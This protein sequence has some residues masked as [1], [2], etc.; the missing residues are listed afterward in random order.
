VKVGVS[1][2]TLTRA[3]LGELVAAAV[4]AERA[5]CATVWVPESWCRDPFGVLHAMGNATRRVHLA[6]GVAILAS[7]TPTAM[8]MA[9]QTL[10]EAHPGRVVL[11][12]GAGHAET[13]EAWHGVAHDSSLAALEEYIAIIRQV[14]SGQPL[15]PAG[16]RWDVRDIASATPQVTSPPPIVVA[17]L[18]PRAQALAAR[19]ADGVV[20]TM[21]STDAV[22]ASAASLQGKSLAA[23][24]MAGLDD[25]DR[26]A[27]GASVALYG[28]W[29]NYR[30]HLERLGFAQASTRLA[31]AWARAGRSAW[32]RGEAPAEAIQAVPDDLLDQLVA[33]GGAAIRKRAEDYAAAGATEVVLRPMIR[34]GAVA[35][36]V[37]RV[38]GVLG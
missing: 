35:D 4:A 28:F 25:T 17:A 19:V 31:D 6:S 36:S 18:G 22:S 14:W 13:V 15:Q 12:L 32:A 9:A 10:A 1:V 3:P 27:A 7:R 37:A 11:G 21:V 38:L 2:P 8:A 24:F 26:R 34:G 33:I 30:R 5:G 20:L 23:S 29:A 16:A